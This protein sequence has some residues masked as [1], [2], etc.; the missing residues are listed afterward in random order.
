ML[1]VRGKILLAISIYL[2]VTSALKLLMPCY[3]L[4]SPHTLAVLMQESC[5]IRRLGALG[6]LDLFLF[7]TN[8]MLKVPLMI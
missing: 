2:L 8:R 1:V 5:G 7:E 6:V 4:A 3:L